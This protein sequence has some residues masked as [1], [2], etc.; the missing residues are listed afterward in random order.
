MSNLRNT[1]NNNNDFGRKEGEPPTPGSRP[2]GTGHLNL[3][4]W[5]RL[6][7]PQLSS[8]LWPFETISSSVSEIL[9]QALEKPSWQTDTDLQHALGRPTAGFV[10]PKN[11]YLSKYG[12]SG[13]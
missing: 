1:T 3:R 11:I 4:N 9:T 12:K 10:S 8:L 7:H 13:Y 6:G 5:S 2:S